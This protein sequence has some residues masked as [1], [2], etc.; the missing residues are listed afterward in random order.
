[1]ASEIFLDTKYPD[2]ITEEVY[3]KIKTE[4]E[5]I[6]LTGMPGSG[7]TTVGKLLAKELNRPYADTDALIEEKTGMTPAQIIAARGEADFR[8]VEAEVIREISQKNGWIISTGGGAILRPENI[9]HLR[10]NG[11]LFFLDRPVEQLIP[12]EDRPLS[13]TKEAILQRYQERHPTYGATADVIVRNDSTP[14][15]AAAQVKK[16]LLK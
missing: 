4:K 14:E 5:N 6:V 15:A 10:S 12:T 3:K 13:S 7:K 8:D 9:R 2:A 11:K 16:E 1:M